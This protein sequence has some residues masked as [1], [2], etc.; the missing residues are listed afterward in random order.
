MSVIGRANRKLAK[1]T[2]PLPLEHFEGYDEYWAARDDEVVLP[3]WE[4]AVARIPD[5]AS[6]LDVGCG[7][8]G[9][10][11]YLLSQRPNARARGTDISPQ[12]VAE[13]RDSGLDTFVADLT[14]EPLDREYDY[15]TAF[16]VIEHIQEAEKALVTMRD[17]TRHLLIM[18]LPNIGFIDHR[19]RL[20]L[21]GRFPNTS[22]KFHAK[23][24]IRHWT[25]RDFTE[26]AGEFGLRVLSVEGQY[27]P[28]W[29][30]WQ[31]HPALFSPQVVY[32][33]ERV[34]D[35]PERV[36]PPPN[37]VRRSYGR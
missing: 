17:A 29:G 23:E 34:R 37:A 7:S 32:T 19:I 15:I 36:E 31:S 9:F 27:G 16:E 13:A 10:L 8:G 26:W 18:S 22:L 14:R 20:G 25:V 4:M 11:R 6:V 2:A 28:P 5:G 1:Y 3:R 30:P 12:A 21:F 35:R 24:H 33:M